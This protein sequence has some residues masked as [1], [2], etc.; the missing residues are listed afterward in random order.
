[1]PG[2]FS[3][4]AILDNVLKRPSLDPRTKAI[5]NQNPE[6]GYWGSVGPDYLFFYPP[7]WPQLE[8]LFQTY[9][10]FDNLTDEISEVFASAGNIFGSSESDI[11]E[12]ITGGLFEEFRG[13]VDALMVNVTSRIAEVITKNVDF[14]MI[15]KPPINEFPYTGQFRQEKWWWIDIGHHTRTTKFLQNLWQHSSGDNSLRSFTYGYMSHM[16]ADIIG[17]PYVNLL[18]GGPYRNHWRR[19]G[20]V[21]KCMDTYIWDKHFGTELASSEAYKLVHFNNP[22]YQHPSMPEHLCN[23]L[24]GCLANTYNDLGIK[25]G[26]P[27]PDNIQLMYRYTYKFIKSASSKSL[28]NLPPPPEDFDWWDLPAEIREKLDIIKNPPSVGKFPSLDPSKFNFR[29]WKA[30]LKSLFDYCSWIADS[31]KI[32][33]GLPVY[34]L[35]R[36]ATTPFRY[37]IWLLMQQIYSLYSASRLA[38]AIGAYVHPDRAQLNGNFMH[39]FKPEYKWLTQYPYEA[40]YP[41]QALDFQTYHLVHPYQF[42]QSQEL[43]ETTP[44]FQQDENVIFPELVLLGE[45]N[46]TTL[47]DFDKSK[48]F[49]QVESDL[50]S[51][52]DRNRMISATD[53]TIKLFELSEK[54]EHVN[55][56]DWNLDGDRGLGWPE[57]LTNK[58]KPWNSYT[59]FIF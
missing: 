54:G 16:A 30:F 20:L 57:W 35:A 39:L 25:S 40:N 29:K 12:M 46:T 9:Y 3:H 47:S 38:L 45:F 42:A 56:P 49:A 59:D 51:L 6:Y 22:P 1:M 21:E 53:Y 15:V 28:L 37:V 50:K 26:I 33:I 10:K 32:I 18:V 4:F 8:F 41:Q 14:Y 23:F 31:I 43:T 13:V 5:I 34:I 58:T 7:D 19:H 2:I 55:L 36:I 44:F 27:T 48:I 11:K 24:S 17:H 52:G